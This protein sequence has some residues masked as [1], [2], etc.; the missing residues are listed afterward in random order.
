MR[1]AFAEFNP[2]DDCLGE[3]TVP[4]GTAF[5]GKLTAGRGRKHD[6]AA[7]LDRHHVVYQ[8]VHIYGS[9]CRRHASVTGIQKP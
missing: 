8:D 5:G 3:G 7:I 6:D 2:F 1:S 4:P 9:T